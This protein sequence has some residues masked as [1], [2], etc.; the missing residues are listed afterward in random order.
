MAYW[1]GCIEPLEFALRKSSDPVTYHNGLFDHTILA[2]RLAE[3]FASWPLSIDDTMVAASVSGY[4][5]ISLKGLCQE[6]F[7]V[8][9]VPY[10]EAGASDPQYLAQDLYLTRQLRD[11]LLPRIRG[12]AY[13]IDRKLIPILVDMSYRGYEVDQEM[14]VGKTE[15]AERTRDRAKDRFEG[16]F[17]DGTVPS[18]GSPKQVCEALGIETSGAEFL[19]ACV[20]IEG[21]GALSEASMWILEYR[22][23]AKL[24]ST[25]LGPMA[26]LERVSGLFNL[27]SNEAG[28]GGAGTGRL[29]SRNFNMQNFAPEA[30]T[31][32]RAPEGYLLLSA[33]FSQIELRVAAEESDSVYLIGAFREGRDLHQETMELL[34]L[35][36]RQ[37][38]KKW[39]FT[40]LYGGEEHRLSAITGKSI[41]WCLNALHRFRVGPWEAFFDWGE[42]HWAEVQRSSYSTSP[43]PFLHRRYIPLLSTKHAAKA[44]KNHPIQSMAVYITKAAMLELAKEFPIMANQIHDEIHVFVP[45]DIDPALTKARAREILI[46]VG[47]RYLPRVGI[48]V[49]VSLSRYWKAK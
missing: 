45:E 32:L 33:D 47:N 19:K 27:T 12:T 11:Y 16:M 42:R 28:E 20:T 7:G 9:T 48:D 37:D 13:D 4:Q 10:T 24:L 3:H 15:I 36:N 17:A 46:E 39:N 21:G 31:C 43:E 6:L 35:D 25:Y 22:K 1:A 41:S 40:T 38:G 26:N 49:S 30:Y 8:A 5:D 2:P 14:V 18:I 44:A 34:G 29:S 23:Q